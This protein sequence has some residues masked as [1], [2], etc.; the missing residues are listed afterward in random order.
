MRACMAPL[1]DIATAPHRATVAQQYAYDR[2]DRLD[3]ES[4]MTPEKKMQSHV[5]YEAPGHF[6]PAMR[7]WWGQVHEVYELEPHHRH[8]LRK[9]CEAYDEGEAARKVLQKEGLT[10]EDRFGQPKPRP[11]AA[12][13]Q[14]AVIRFAR[15]LR[16]LQLDAAADARPPRLY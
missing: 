5:I 14:A 7:E 9:T 15:L 3:G 6:S 10:Y 1:V 13:H 8:T 2:R 11:E 12:I 4:D 16:E